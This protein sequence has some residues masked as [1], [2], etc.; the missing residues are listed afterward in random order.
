MN[1][2]SLKWAMAN[3]IKLYFDQEDLKDDIDYFDYF[4]CFDDVDYNI[5]YFDQED[6]KDDIDGNLTAKSWR[7]A[8]L[9]INRSLSQIGLYTENC[10][11]CC[12]Y[13]CGFSIYPT[14]H[15]C[16]SVWGPLNFDI[17]M[18]KDTNSNIK[19]WRIFMRSLSRESLKNSRS[20]SE[21]IFLTNMEYKYV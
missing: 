12:V 7:H 20:T 17:W 1:I 19:H 16:R 11:F 2:E 10:Q 15:P 4:Y 13:S 14:F 5:D 6:I 9:G 8:R 21:N 3:A 18:V